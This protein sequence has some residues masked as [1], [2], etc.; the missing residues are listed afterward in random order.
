MQRWAVSFIGTLAL[1][2]LVGQGVLALHA[3]DHQAHGSGDD[4]KICLT[5]QQ[6][7]GVVHTQGLV[8]SIFSPQCAHKTVTRIF[9]QT[10]TLITLKPRAPPS[11]FL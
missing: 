5:A 3:Y 1:C 11:F 9:Y 4:C 10:P 6:N 2:F 7:A 8:H